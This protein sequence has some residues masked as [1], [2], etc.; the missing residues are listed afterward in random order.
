VRLGAAVL[1]VTLPFLVLL[2]SASPVE[3]GKAVDGVV[4]LNTAPP[5][6]L[7]LLPGIGPAK[8]VA[9]LTYRKRRPFR[10]VDELVRIKGVGR[11]MV[12][13]L[14]V[15]LAVAGPTTAIA[16]AVK[17]TPGAVSQPPKPMAQPAH[18]P[19]PLACPPTPPTA[20]PIPPAAARARLRARLPDRGQSVARPWRASC[21]DPA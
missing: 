11:K 14:R 3:A 17:A 12:R 21:L 4:N 9:I 7:A 2:A 8:A 19:H 10:T 6:V 13:G 15:H 18:R 1:W 5:E 20:H 16:A